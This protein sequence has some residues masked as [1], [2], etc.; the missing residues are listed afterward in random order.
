MSADKSRPILHPGSRS[1]SNI[2]CCWGSCCLQ[3]SSITLNSRIIEP[4]RACIAY[5][6]LHE[7]VHFLPPNHSR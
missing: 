4:T 3:K 1:A 6:V 5:V 2:I 7:L